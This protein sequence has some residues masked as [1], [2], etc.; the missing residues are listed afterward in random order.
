MST[1]PQHSSLIERIKSVATERYGS[2]DTPNFHFVGH[3]LESS[4]VRA[5]VQNI[6]YLSVNVRENTDPNDDVAIVLIINVG[7]EYLLLQLSI[8]AEYAVFRRIL[9]DN[10][11]YVIDG[12]DQAI[13][14]VEKSIVSLIHRIGYKL[15]DRETLSS[16]IE[17]SSLNT[18]SEDTNVYNILFSDSE[19]A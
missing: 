4:P 11:T 8:I 3:A 9:Q 5:I 18:P 14:E 2:L 19:L 12:E 7:Q 6:K 1:S 15:L 10:K 17:M 16:R 13:T